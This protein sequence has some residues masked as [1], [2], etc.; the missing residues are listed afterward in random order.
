MRQTKLFTK[1]RK[2]APK[3]EVSKNAQLLIRAGFVHKE[4]A[5]V[6]A[7]LPLGIK[8]IEKIKTIVREEM[9]KIDSSEIIMTSLQRK[10][11][12]E[13]TDRWDDNKV[14][15]WFKSKLKNGVEVG[16]G[17]SHEEQITDMMK[18]FVT[19][20]R[21]LPVYVYQFQNKLR[22]E[23]RAKSG[24]MRGREFLMKDLYSY[25]LNQEEHQ[26]FYDLVIEAYHKIFARLG[27]GDKTFFTFASG[28]AF[29]QFSHEF[30]TLCDAGEDIIYLSRDK[31]LAINEEVM[32]PDVLDQLGL[33]KEDLE[34]VKSAEVG[35]IFNFG[36]A[37][38]EELGLVIR[39]SEG[40]DMPVILGSYGIGVSRVMGVL[41]ELFADENG[42][43][44][45][46]S[47]APYQVHL[48]SLCKETGDVKI[49][50]KLYQDM[51]AAGIEVLYDDR[52]DVRAGQKFA[53]SDLI[54]IPVRLIVST[55]TLEKQSVEFK[56]RHELNSTF[57]SVNK[58][59]QTVQ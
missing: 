1:T 44:W 20:Y 38:S 50:D 30:Q 4:M 58:V 39:D 45:P 54:G 27:I 8:V 48:V 2:E 12:W 42:L 24:I 22:N 11:L 28:G 25:S 23:L 33:K 17:W 55:K 32:R 15:I 41:V 5:G 57:V 51:L 14:D 7:Y 34:M 9:N 40:K 56:N 49:A 59:I 18:N 36:S 29:T 6:Y 43:V 3:D 19:S 31:K 10:E 47:I 21:D 26:K 37:K 53:D 35:N 16:F 52:E 13:K 46:K